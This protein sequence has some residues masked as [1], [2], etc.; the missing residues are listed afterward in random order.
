[1]TNNVAE[2]YTLVGFKKSLLKA[3]NISLTIIAGRYDASGTVDGKPDYEIIQNYLMSLGFK[4]KFKRIHQLFWWGFCV[5]FLINRS[6]IYNKKN[7][8]VIFA[9]KGNKKIPFYQSFS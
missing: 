1:I 6:W 7:Y 5:R 8:G 4:T 3:D 9:S 2:Y